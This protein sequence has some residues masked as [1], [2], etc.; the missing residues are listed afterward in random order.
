MSCICAYAYIFEYYICSIF[1]A[2]EST[3]FVSEHYAYAYVPYII[4]FCILWNATYD[5]KV[6]KKKLINKGIRSYLVIYHQQNV[7]QHL[8]FR[9]QS[10][11]WPSHA[12]KPSAHVCS[13]RSPQFPYQLPPS[14]QQLGFPKLVA[15]HL[16]HLF[17]VPGF[18][19]WTVIC[20][21][22]GISVD[23]WRSII[24]SGLWPVIMVIAGALV[25]ISWSRMKA[26]HQSQ[27]CL[28]QKS[29]THLY[30]PRA[31]LATYTSLDRRDLHIS[32]ANYRPW[33]SK[34]VC[35]DQWRCTWDTSVWRAD[36]LSGLQFWL[37]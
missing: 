18:L 3:S 6:R 15:T 17:V 12:S 33:H 23:T 36:V 2:Q 19:C 11:Q 27:F 34:K 35:L 4:R 30:T 13:R 21:V 7:S 24:G 31:P 10:I 32:G 16:G 29:S 9:K 26:P 8:Y 20:V 22:W 25:H 37:S 14:A 28:V 1:Y 5:E